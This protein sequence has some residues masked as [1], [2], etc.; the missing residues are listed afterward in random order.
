[1]LT[2]CVQYTEPF[3]TKMP[4]SNSKRKVFNNDGHIRFYV[5]KQASKWRCSA[6]GSIVLRGMRH[7]TQLHFLLSST[8]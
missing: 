2:F 4:P 6:K 5:A 7:K 1:M 8:C 3:V